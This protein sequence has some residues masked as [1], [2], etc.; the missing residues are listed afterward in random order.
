MT[1]R[2]LCASCAAQTIS[3]LLATNLRL[4]AVDGKVLLDTECDGCG[5]RKPTVVRYEV[6]RRG[7][8]G[9]DR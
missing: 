9:A 7:P 1:V 5:K 2:N 3:G 4:A 8:D 6:R